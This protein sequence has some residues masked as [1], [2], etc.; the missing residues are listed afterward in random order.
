MSNVKMIFELNQPWCRT[1]CWLLNTLPFSAFSMCKILC[2]EFLI[3]LN[4][5][6]IVEGERPDRIN[7]LRGLNPTTCTCVLLH[8]NF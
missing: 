3:A 5:I 1:V 4:S 7:F 8:N 6:Y 2:M